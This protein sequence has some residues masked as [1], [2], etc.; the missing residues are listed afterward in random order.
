M[1]VGSLLFPDIR[2]DK[3]KTKTRHLRQCHRCLGEHGRQGLR[4][5][6]LET[7]GTLVFV[8]RTSPAARMPSGKRILIGYDLDFIRPVRPVEP[9]LVRVPDHTDGISSA[10]ILTASGTFCE[11]LCFGRLL[12]ITVVNGT[13]SPTAGLYQTGTQSRVLVRT[14]S[15]EQYDRRH[16]QPFPRLKRERQNPGRWSQHWSF[17]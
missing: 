17:G 5:E 3:I 12:R 7:T 10:R 9:G 6:S 14:V 4:V 2:P 8:Y 13:S 11:V 15:F 16:V 1:L